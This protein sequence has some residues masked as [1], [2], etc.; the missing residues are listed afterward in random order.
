MLWPS[1]PG[2][3]KLSNGEAAGKVCNDLKIPMSLRGTGLQTIFAK[4]IDFLPN[5]ESTNMCFWGGEE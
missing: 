3:A 1:E 5:P 4:K 2:T